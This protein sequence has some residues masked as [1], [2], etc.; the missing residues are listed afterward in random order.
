M[1]KGE[2]KG[3]QRYKDREVLLD[4]LL[5]M[6]PELKQLQGGI[7]LLRALGDTT[8]AVEPVALAALAQCCEGG[9]ERVMDLWRSSLNTSR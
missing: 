6:E 4:L 2:G 5:E 1:R 8:D 3:K 7:T 9:L